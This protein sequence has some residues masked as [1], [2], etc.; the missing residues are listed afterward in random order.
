M[1][2]RA[3]MNLLRRLSLLG[4]AVVLAFGTVTVAS[5]QAF[6]EG[7][8]YTSISAPPP[9]QTA[10]GKIEVREFFWYGCPH[11]YTLEPHIHNWRKPD[12]VEFIK[13]P[14]LLGKNWVDH[15]YTYY[16]LQALG[17]LEELHL[18]LFDALHSKNRRLFTI[19]QVGK[20][21]EDHGIERKTF[22]A[23]AKSFAVD[24]QVKRA[25]RLGKAYKIS[26]VPTFV[27][28]GKYITSPNMAG[29]YEQFFKVVDYLIE[30]ERR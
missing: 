22:E 6:V 10:K 11:C 17:R 3:D 18:V 20:F 7:E 29:G 12:A 5:A 13:T 24:T 21:L 4:G 8:H 9:V 14:A 30:K 23:A 15:A 25:E 19:E 16:A 1:R 2:G 28:N 27:I 26:S